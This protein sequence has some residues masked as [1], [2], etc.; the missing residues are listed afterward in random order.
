VALATGSHAAPGAVENRYF[1]SLGGILD[2]HPVDAFIKE[3]RQNGK[4]VSI[5]LDVCYAVSAT[6]ERKDRFAI[7]LKADDGRLTGAGA[8][9]EDKSPV[10]IDLMRK[11]VGKTVTFEGKLTIGDR[12]LPV[13][14]TGNTEID[15]QEFQQLQVTDDGLAQAPADFTEV[16]PQSLAVGVKREA[17]VDLVKSLRHEKVQIALE[18]LATDCATLRSGVQMLRL[19]VDP[20]RSG[21]L[22]AKLKAAPGVTAVGW[23]TGGYELERAIRIPAAAWRDGDSLNKD[24]FAAAL[25][26][27]AAKSMTATIAATRWNDVTGELTIALKR[28]NSGLPA[29]DLIDTIEIAALVGPETPGASERLIV[30]FG[31]PTTTTRDEAAGPHLEFSDAATGEEDSPFGDDEEFLEALTAGLKGQRW[32]ADTSSWR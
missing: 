15:E 9:L 14:S 25:A 28:P 21:A 1:T 6:S 8:T 24:G 10:A 3:T 32:D 7:D 5:V 30:W 22:A 31:L 17:L 26:Q 18:S 16:S 2:D 19:V 13:S 11:P 27:I 29:L 23:A 20:A 4:I 12:V